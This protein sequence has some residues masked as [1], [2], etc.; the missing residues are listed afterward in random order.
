MDGL[1]P[2]AMF[3]VYLSSI[4]RNFLG[5]EMERQIE[6]IDAGLTFFINSEMRRL[7]RSVQPKATNLSTGFDSAPTILTQFTRDEVDLFFL[8][9]LGGGFYEL[10]FSFVDSRFE[11][12]PDKVLFYRMIRDF[13]LRHRITLRH[14]CLHDSSTI[15]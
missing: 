9:R 10:A 2:R 7:C 4:F 12:T 15:H 1:V 5:E 14:R 6:R 8:P 3:T 13:S 11:A